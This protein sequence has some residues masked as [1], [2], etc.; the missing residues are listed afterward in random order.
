MTVF[1]ILYYT[2]SFVQSIPCIYKLIKTKSSKD[3]SLLNR[4]CQYSALVFF[5]VY[6]FLNPTSTNIVKIIG[7]IDLGLLTTENIFILI[8]RKGNNNGTN[9]IG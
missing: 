7:I 9:N 6:V 8:Y 2:L 1:L 5:T 3:Y 4:L